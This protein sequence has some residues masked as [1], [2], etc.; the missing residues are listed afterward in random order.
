MKIIICKNYEEL[1]QKGA[2]MIADVI[3]SN[4][5][6]VLGLATGNSPIGIYRHLV[7]AYE[8]GEIDFSNVRSFNLDEYLPIDPAD[9]NSYCAFMHEH[10][11]DKV[12]M[13]SENCNIPSGKSVDGAEAECRAYDARIEAAGGIDIQL[14]GIGRNGHIGFNEPAGSLLMGTHPVQL[15]EST[16]AANGPLFDDPAKMPRHAVTMGLGAIFAAKKVLLVANGKSKHE[17][18]KGMLGD[19]LTTAI[20]A[21][22]L[23]LHPDL[24]LICDEEAYNG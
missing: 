4:P 8:R 1:S 15:T 18:I 5:K 20:P 21:S 11:W 7:A 24:T 3:K 12:N 10:L 19:E 13:K 17:A 23:K 2:E 6:A 22:L 9:P 16:L 14:L